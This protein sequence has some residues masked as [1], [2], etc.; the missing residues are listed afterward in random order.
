MKKIMTIAT[1]LLV[2]ISILN[3]EPESK[4]ETSFKAMF[5][6]A[7][8]VKWHQDKSG[9]LVSFTQSGSAV[10]IMYDGK[11]KFVQ[12]LRYYS[13]KDLPTNILLAVKNKYKGKAIYGVTER[14]TSNEVSYHIIVS[15]GSM[16]ENIVAYSNGT[17]TRDTPI[18][19]E[20][21]E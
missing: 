21:A 18:T 5:P 4:V 14:T 20:D 17:V 3:A 1:A 8:N 12:S 10:K 7:R 11:G 15:N 2:T 9:Y 16:P 6:N 13:E 19:G